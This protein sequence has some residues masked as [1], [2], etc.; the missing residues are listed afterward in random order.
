MYV[1]ASRCQTLLLFM[2]AGFEDCSKVF[3][4]DP[5]IGNSSLF[6]KSYQVC[7]IDLCVFSY[8]KL[9]LVFS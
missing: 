7:D 1:Y 9:S 6:T 2:L 4:C 3:S 8:C 5:P